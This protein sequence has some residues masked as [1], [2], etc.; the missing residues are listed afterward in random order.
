MLIEI[1]G[2]VARV[3]VLSRRFFRSVIGLCNI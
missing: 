2:V 1:P 3:K